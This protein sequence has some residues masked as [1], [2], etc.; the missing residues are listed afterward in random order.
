MRVFLPYR[1]PS[2]KVTIWTSGKGPALEES[3]GAGERS[4][5]AWGRSLMELHYDLVL[6]DCLVCQAGSH[7]FRSRMMALR[8][9]R[10]FRMQAVRACLAGFPEALSF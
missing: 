1:I 6:S 5:G 2:R 4:L 9:T 8:M 3:A 7:G 10:S